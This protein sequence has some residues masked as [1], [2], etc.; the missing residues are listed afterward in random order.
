MAKLRFGDKH[1]I[2]LVTVFSD[3]SAVYLPQKDSNITDDFQYS[4]LRKQEDKSLVE[5]IGGEFVCFDFP[6]ALLRNISYPLLQKGIFKK[7]NKW[8]HKIYKR[9]SDSIA[10]YDV[11]NIFLPSG[12]GWHC[13][14]QII[15]MAA[16]L[17]LKDV[18]ANQ[19]SIYLYEDYPYCNDVRYN[20]W[21]RL[22]ELQKMFIMDAY[23]VDITN[24]VSEKTK[25]S[26]IYRSQFP[27]WDHRKIKGEF[28]NLARSTAIEAS[29]MHSKKLDFEY[30]ERIW[31]ITV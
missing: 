18:L 26:Y 31:K 20:Y 10:S 6:E 17:L 29:L 19:M 9:L 1:D 24:F 23:Y 27:D 2:L 30:A 11:K 21:G 12:F 16:D 3:Y 28:M 8:A 22:A 15:T 7:D 5:Y 4:L 25:M 14:H 13:D